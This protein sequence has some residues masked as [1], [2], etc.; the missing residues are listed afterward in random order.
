MLSKIRVN[1]KKQPRNVN[2]GCFG[3]VEPRGIEPQSESRKTV[4][5]LATFIF[6]SN[7]VSKISVY[8]RIDFIHSIRHGVG[9]DL[10]VHIIR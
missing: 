9:I 1:N 10:F 2:L 3:V 5:A 8:G 6:V 7:F 4:A